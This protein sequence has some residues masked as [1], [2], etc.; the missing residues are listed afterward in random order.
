MQLDHAQRRAGLL[1][2]AAILA[3]TLIFGV[4]LVAKPTSVHAAGTATVTVTSN[5]PSGLF[6]SVLLGPSFTNFTSYGCAQTGQPLTFQAPLGSTVYW[7]AGSDCNGQPGPTTSGSF[8]V[9]TTPFSTS[10]PGN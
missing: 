4:S 7:Q 6:G 5:S 3:F 2:L 8:T 9:N 1:I 10:L